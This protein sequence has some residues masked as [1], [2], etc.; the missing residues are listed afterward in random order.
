MDNPFPSR[1]EI[2]ENRKK[3]E[4]PSYQQAI[5]DDIK[6]ID[7]DKIDFS[8]GD[9]KPRAKIV[10]KQ[11]VFFWIRLFLKEENTKVS[12]NDDIVIEYLPT[13]EKLEVK[14]ICYAKK[15]LDKDNKDEIINYNTED[16]KKILCLMIDSDRINKNSQDIP[17]IRTLF[18]IGLHYEYQILKRDELVFENLNNGEIYEYYDVEF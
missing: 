16:D 1:K 12:P 17:F 10:E 13:G 3:S 6:T 8:N 18:K 11:K 4:L 14:F 15:G 7:V 2:L 9:F 5:V